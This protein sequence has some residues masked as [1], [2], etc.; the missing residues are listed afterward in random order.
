MELL[1]QSNNVD[2]FFDTK[3]NILVQKWREKLNLEDIDL[4]GLSYSFDE[5]IRTQLY[6]SPESD[7]EAELKIM[8]FQW[9]PNLVAHA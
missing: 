8:L 2:I 7:I 3:R 4:D 1:Y 6:E 5:M 9:Y